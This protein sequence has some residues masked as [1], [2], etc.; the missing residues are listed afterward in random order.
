MGIIGM[1]VYFRGLAG[2]LP[3]YKGMEPFF[4][5]ALSQ[6]VTLVVIGAD[7]VEQLEENVAFARTYKAMAPGEQEALVEAVSPYARELMYYKP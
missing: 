3:W 7:T 6:A 1:K 2:R 4:R 5:F